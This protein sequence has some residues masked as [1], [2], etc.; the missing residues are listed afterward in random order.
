[1]SIEI[2]YLP[3]TDFWLRPCVQGHPRLTLVP[4]ERTYA[5]AY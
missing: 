4:I 2:L 1:M 3:K 5:T